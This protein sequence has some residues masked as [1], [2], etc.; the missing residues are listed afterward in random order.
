MAMT[1]TEKI[2]ARASGK[3]AVAPGRQRLGE[4]RRPHDPRRVR[5]GDHRHLQARVRG[6]REGVGSRQGRDHSR[7]LH[8]HRR[9]EVPPQRRHPA[10]VR[11][12]A[13][14]AALLRRRHASD[15]KGVCHIALAA[16][17]ALPA[18]RG[19]LRHRLAQLHG[20]R[21]QPIRDRHRQ[22]RRGVHPRHRQAAG[23]GAADDA[24]RLRRRVPAL[25]ARQG[26]HPA[27]DRRDRRRRRHLQGDGVRA[28]RRCSASRWK[29]A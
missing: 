18:G 6:Q 17:G 16:G 13:G 26:R 11:E 2:L 27:P 25:G 7:P 19:A 10:R 22:H 24:L 14:P 15:Y 9:R 4:R 20:G 1:M 29:S 23:E 12:G 8:L 5:A 21:L 28:A 3:A